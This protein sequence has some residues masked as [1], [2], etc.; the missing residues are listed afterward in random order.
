M[1]SFVTCDE[2][3]LSILFERPQTNNQFDS[4]HNNLFNY[5]I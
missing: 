4:S 5:E 3:G 2:Q 1:I